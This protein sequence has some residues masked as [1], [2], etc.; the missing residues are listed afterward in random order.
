MLQRLIRYC[1]TT[2]YPWEIWHTYLTNLL[3]S[4]P[5]FS[6]KQQASQKRKL[7]IGFCSLFPPFPNGTAAASYYIIQKLANLEDIELRLI[8]LKN[9][10]DKKLFSSLHV[11]FTTPEDHTL[12]V[13]LFFGLGNEYKKYS[14]HAYAKKVAWQTLHED[15][16]THQSEQKIIDQLR[17]A[18]LVLA[19]TKWTEI[20]YK[21]QLAHVA[22]VP[23]G[24]DTKLFKR[25]SERKRF[26]CLFVSRIHY[27][28]GIAPFLDAIPL[29][30]EKDQDIY[31][32][33]VAPHDKNSPYLTEIY[34]KIMCLT[35]ERYKKNIEIKTEWIPYNFIPKIY[36]E[37]SVLIF[38]SNNEGFGLP[39]IEAM[40]AEVPCIV[41]DKKPM[42]E[43]I[44][45]GKTGFC[46]SAG[47]EEEKYHNFAFPD[48][49]EI[50]EKILFLKKNPRKREEMGKEGRK[51][52][53]EH[54]ALPNIINRLVKYCEII[55]EKE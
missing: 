32:R 13:I 34:E 35:E 17:D 50:A 52:V 9:K 6:K 11:L 25:A 33:I 48:P 15:P 43:I 53:L 39:L 46:L 18:D 2:V 26:I 29:V 21:K 47:K 19:L 20:I 5:F 24:V 38:P 37:A 44:V 40:S 14:K 8:P 31:F 41:L 1:N 27:Y 23:L 54:Y 7:R 42:S 45:H 3:D 55:A 22:Y 30:L 12:D 36:S 49:K 28:K 16:A 10:I 51:R 4:A